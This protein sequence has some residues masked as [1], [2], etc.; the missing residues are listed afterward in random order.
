MIISK[1]PY[2]VS[3]FGGGSDYPQWYKKYGGEVLS[4]TIDKYVYLTCRKL[5]AFFDHKY[6]IVYSNVEL[7]KKIGDIKHPAVREI[8][9]KYHTEINSGLEIHYDGDLPA[10][11][12]VGSS[13]SFVVGLINLI[14]K[15]NREN[16]IKQDL[17]KKSIEMEQKILGEIV[18]SQDQIAAAYGGLNNIKF[19][20]NGGFKVNKIKLDKQHMNRFSKN[21]LMIFSGQQRTAKFIAKSYVNK[22][23]KDKKRYL[24]EIISHVKIAKNLIQR[25]NF[26]DFG[27]LLNENWIRKRELSKNVTTGIIEEIYDQ[28]ISGGALGGKLLGAG[29]GGFLLMYVKKNKLK[30]LKKKLKGLAFFPINITNEGSKIIFN[31]E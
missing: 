7:C 12:G 28:C 26:D 21:F 15:I 5:P 14:K 16:I 24:H 31:H 18:G 23:A 6:R 11:S 3:F 17:A 2:R 10:R 4:C 22:L 27:R 29:G 9:K 1:T 13:S 30:E 20:T 19:L 25:Q 8:I